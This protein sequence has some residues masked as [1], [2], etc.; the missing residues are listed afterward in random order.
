MLLT[1]NMDREGDGWTGKTNGKGQ[2]TKQN[3][4][5]IASHNQQKQSSGQRKQTT[6][7]QTTRKQSTTTMKLTKQDNQS[8]VS[9]LLIDI[10]SNNDCDSRDVV[11]V[12]V[13]VLVKT[14]RFCVV[15]AVKTEN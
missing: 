8:C 5:N 11:V 10:D 6:I 13:A 3:E 4:I 12:V 15:M 7:N 2:Q 1:R 9:P 14:H